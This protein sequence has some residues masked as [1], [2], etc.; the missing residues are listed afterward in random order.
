MILSTICQNKDII[1][2]VVGLGI[3]VCSLYVAYKDLRQETYVGNNFTSKDAKIK[4]FKRV[5]KYLRNNRRDFMEGILKDF[6]KY[7]TYFIK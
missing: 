6:Y 5:F 2:S 4:I 1:I 3:S 7:A